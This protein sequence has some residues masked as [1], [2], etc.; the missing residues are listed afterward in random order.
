MLQYTFLIT[1]LYFTN[2]SVGITDSTPDISI[3]APVDGGT[4]RSTECVKQLSRN[5]FQIK[6][7]VEEKQNPL[8]H[9]VSRLDLVCRNDGTKT[10]IITLHLD[11]SGDGL[12]T[13]FDDNMYGGMPLRDFIFIQPSNQSWKQVDGKTE[14]WVCT[15]SFPVEPGETKLGLSPWYT[16][17]DYLSF[18]NS[19]PE[20][21]H[22]K[23][24]LIGLSDKEREHWEL[25][26]TD[27]EE[28]SLQN[29]CCVF[30]HAREHAYETFSSFAIEGLLDYL[31]SDSAADARRRF[32]FVIHPMTNVDG[33]ADGYEYRVG[34]DYPDPKGTR[35]G[36]LTF[37]TIDRLR[38][39]YF[40]TWHN[41]IAPRNI[42]TL[43]YTDAQNEQPS[44]RAWDLFTQRFPSSHGVD[45]RWENEDNPLKNN[46][47]GRSL[48]DNNIHQY[49][50]KHY[51]SRIWGWE[52]P[53]WNRN[54]DDARK[55]GTDFAKAFLATLND[56]DKTQQI[57]PSKVVVNDV[58]R[59][60]IYEFELHGKSW[61]DNPFCQSS[62]IG[63]F[64]SPSNRNLTVE[65]FYDGGDTWRIRFAPN[66]EGEWRYI[67]RGE[68]VEIFQEGRLRCV[69]SKNRGFIHIHPENPYAFAYDNGDPFFPM[70][71]TCYGFYAD[72]HITPELR[73]QYLKVRRY[74]N[75]NFIRMGVIHSQDHWNVDSK[76]WP[77]GGTPQNQDLD[78]YNTEF[79]QGL[80]KVLS[81]MKS[82]GMNAELILLNFYQR[83]FTDT[84]LWTSRR[85][86]NWLR[87]IIARY[88]AFSNLFQ[89]TIS[90]EYETHPDGDYRLDIPDDV[91]WV[92]TTAKFIRQHDPYRHQI[93]VHP[94]ISANIRGNRTNDSFDPPW[95]IGEF[96]GQCD[97]IGVLSQQTGQAGIWDE[98]LQCCI[99]DD[100]FL[101]DSLR[102]DRNFQKPVMNTENG[103]EFL[104]DYPTYNQ[105]VH[106]TDK[107]RR[108]S[109]RIVCAGGYFSSGFAG[110]LGQSDFWV[111]INLESE[112]PFIIKDEG[113]AHQLSILYSFFN[114]L[115][116]WVMLPFDGVSKG[117]VALA[118][119]GNLYVIYTPKG[120][121]ITV[122]LT[123]AKGDLTVKWFDPRNGEFKEI[124]VISGKGIQEFNTPDENDW[125]LYI[126]LQK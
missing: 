125:V 57:E 110:T 26:V 69:N 59:Y 88:S 32:V 47:V 28:V 79:F 18:I 90:N 45:H 89:W 46:W 109:W 116:Y 52:M 122:N 120:G 42:D 40:V 19:L 126:N 91:E 65:G 14:G 73:S 86:K 2:A 111:K 30:C 27:P 6:A 29:K 96:F 112:Y 24:E 115:P 11:L 34:Y 8:T 17:G 66:E 85:E 99:G 44:R 117:A 121:K 38:P 21:P 49:A 9:A 20:H 124:G 87:Y 83:P 36:K 55:A 78:R 100:P 80:D 102:I 84:S 58:P 33:V 114:N 43:F 35:S 107:V 60:E 4:P 72:S 13:N 1:M 105:Q 82:V 92:K 10:E 70:G 23:K 95:R 98:T 101:V 25:T 64:L 50:M 22:L 31:L 62:V 5:E 77:W 74:Q 103:Y 56:L 16:Y 61:V 93:T 94:V 41:W 3:Y 71:D 54:T 53:W 67:I 81:E 108:S 113:V 123:D 48:S 97:E 76:F 15:V 7:F 12:R 37:D 63:E 39:N 68:G 119:I 104:R 51:G 75:F 106:H 118:D